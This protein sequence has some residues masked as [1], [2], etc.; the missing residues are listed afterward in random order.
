MKDMPFSLIHVNMHGSFMYMMALQ[1]ISNI[2][3]ITACLNRTIVN[4]YC[5]IRITVRN[6]SNQL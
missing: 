1:T 4:K 2:I 3:Q 6:T 5:I